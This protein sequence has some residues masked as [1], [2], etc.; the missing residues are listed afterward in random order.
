MLYRYSCG[1]I[2]FGTDPAGYAWIIKE[3]DTPRE[4]LYS[5]GYC[6]YRRPMKDK[7]RIP[8]PLAEAGRVMQGLGALLSDGISFRQLVAALPFQR[9]T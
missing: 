9:S 8:L 5:Y 3:C 7:T 2:G 4:D 6:L 1:C